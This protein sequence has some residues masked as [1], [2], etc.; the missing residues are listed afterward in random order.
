MVNVISTL[1][2]EELSD[3]ICKFRGTVTGNNGYIYG[4][5]GEARQVINSIQSTNPPLK[6]DLTLVIDGRSGLAVP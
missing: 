5:P 1:V 2:G 6:L 4:I 3:K